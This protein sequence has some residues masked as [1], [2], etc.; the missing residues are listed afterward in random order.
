MGQLSRNCLSAYTSPRYLKSLIELEC[1]EHEPHPREISC[2]GVQRS[3]R[4]RTQLQENV[5]EHSIGMI[6]SAI[7]YREWRNCENE[8]ESKRGSRSDVPDSEEK[9]SYHLSQTICRQQFSWRPHPR[10]Q[11]EGQQMGT[12]LPRLPSEKNARTEGQ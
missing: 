5:A 8:H 4:E 2:I 7:H 11:R 9:R 1:E 3:G 10:A 12:S 6:G